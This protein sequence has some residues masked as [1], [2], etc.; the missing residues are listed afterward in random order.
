[1]LS[2]DMDF[3][4]VDDL[5]EDIDQVGF[6]NAVLK[7]GRWPEMGIFRNSFW[8]CMGLLPVWSLKYLLKLA[9]LLKPL[10]KQTCATGMRLSESSLQACP[11]LSSS[12]NWE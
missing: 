1:M 11:I 3:S 8:Y 7:V 6:H 4:F 12:R 10:S 2:G 9:K 5:F